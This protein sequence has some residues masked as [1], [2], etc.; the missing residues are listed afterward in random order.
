[1]AFYH[2]MEEVMGEITR[3][4]ANQEE[5]LQSRGEAQHATH[6]RNV[7]LKELLLLIENPVSF[8]SAFHTGHIH[9]DQFSI[10]NQP[11]SNGTLA[12]SLSY[13]KRL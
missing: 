2:H 5:L 13:P 4:G 7:V 11:S 10:N 12:N 9:A 1:M 6:Q 3:Y 8:Q